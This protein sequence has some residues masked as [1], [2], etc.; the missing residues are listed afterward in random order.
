MKLNF[1]TPAL[2]AALLAAVGCTEHHLTP[3]D[4][5]SPGAVKFSTLIAKT[6]AYDN[7]WER[8]DT[9]GVYMV[10]S[11]ETPDE[12]PAA[13]GWRGL[14]EGSIRGNMAYVT[15]LE[16]GETAPNVTF[17][18]ADEENTLRW[19]PD[20]G[21]FDFVAYYPRLASDSIVD[22]I[23]PISLSAQEPQ[24]AIDLMWSNNA[25]GV[26]ETEG[27]CVLSFSHRLTK[28]IFNIEDTD[29]ASLEGMT[30]A[31]SG[32][33]STGG[34]DLSTGR[35]VTDGA[36]EEGTEDEETP[37]EP[38]DAVLTA[39]YDGDPEDDD[40]NDGV[41][42]R[43][44][45]E[46]I[47]MPGEGLDY[48]I[49]FG[50][51]GGETAVFSLTDA[52]YLS[53]KRYIY[54]LRFA[55][56]AP[57]VEFLDTDGDLKSIVAWED[58]TESIADPVIKEP[59]VGGIGGEKGGGEGG[60]A[61][62][63]SGLITEVSPKYSLACDNGTYSDSGYVIQQ[64]EEATVKMSFDGEVTSVAVDVA[65]T[66]NGTMSPGKIRSVKVGDTQLV[67]SKNGTATDDVDVPVSKDVQGEFIFVPSNGKPLT[68]EVEIV[69]TVNRQTILLREFSI[70]PN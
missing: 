21:K 47:V 23:Y 40:D 20:G 15:G 61:G 12:V 27:E 1:A 66:G 5:P 60:G 30:A 65:F 68:G 33:P 58:E 59:G 57:G 37:P 53:G 50:L 26:S 24:R 31:I 17:T 64:G 3:E 63:S 13:G 42:E 14:D 49:V 43:A 38:F 16:E 11:A 36:D 19:P 41:K 39:C 67:V 45:V 7:L 69:V 6:R 62:W 2:A 29:G 22:Y 25:S 52:I 54:N 10:P 4:D 55:A 8:G 44:V 51:E 32:L 9:I 56:P 46:A 28:L 35:F 18:G 34:F 70:N 48:K